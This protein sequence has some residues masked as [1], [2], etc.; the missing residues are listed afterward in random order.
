MR[1]YRKTQY[2][3]C[4]KLLAVLAVIC[5]IQLGLSESFSNMVRASLGCHKFCRELLRHPSG[6]QS[7]TKYFDMRNIELTDGQPQRIAEASD[8]LSTRESSIGHRSCGL[9]VV[10]HPSSWEREWRDNIDQLQSD[11]IFWTSGCEAMRRADDLTE[12]W[13]EYCEHRASNGVDGSPWS[14]EVFSFH[15]YIDSCTKKSVARVPLEPLVGTLRHPR[16]VCDAGFAT[17]STFLCQA[18]EILF[19]KKRRRGKSRALLNKDY[20][21]PLSWNDFMLVRNQTFASF[22]S[23]PRTFFFDL[24][25]STYDNG[26]GGPSLSWFIDSYR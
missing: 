21:L 4:R 1:D 22:S 23:E 9:E 2:Q 7:R 15:E 25:A 20:L 19:G 17:C 5:I 8:L 12:R 26:G 14:H 11:D 6:S 3:R 16:A 18:H 24:G 10:Y 13:L